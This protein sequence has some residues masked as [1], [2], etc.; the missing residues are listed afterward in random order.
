MRF[1]D[2]TKG[3]NRT[4]TG[5]SPT[6]NYEGAKAFKLDAM[7]ELYSAVCT[8][9]LQPKFYVGEVSKQLQQLRKLI[10]SVSPEMVAKL[11]VYAREK[12]HL[13]SVPLVLAVELAKIHKDDALVGK[14]TERVIQRA[15]ELYEILSYYKQANPGTKEL[16]GG[17]VKSLFKI[18]K[19]LKRGI[20]KAF[21][22]FDEYQFGKYNRDTDIKLRDAMF[23][24]HPKPPSGKIE[25]YKK[26]ADDTLSTPFTWETVLTDRMAEA[27]KGIKATKL[28]E[29]AANA[30]LARTKKLAWEE[31]I[32]SKKVGYMA[33]LRN[34][35]NIMEAVVSEEHSHMVLD[36][37][38]NKEAVE[39]SRQLPFRFYSAYKEI[40]GLKSWNVNQVTEAL[41]TAMKYS[42]AN[43]KGFDA[44]SKVLIACDMSGSMQYPLH[45]KSKVRYYEIGLVLGM[46]LQF[47]CAK[48]M[49]GLFGK[50]W[51][52]ETFWKDNILKNSHAFAG[53][54]GCVGHATNGWKILDWAIKEKV[55]FDKVAFFTDCQ[56]WDSTTEVIYGG[57]SKRAVDYWRKYKELFPDAKAY[58]FDLKGYGTT[59]LFVNEMDVHLIG[60]WSD[61]IFEVLDAVEQGSTAI[62]EI[63]KVE[64]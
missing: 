25:L 58:Y 11:A 29:P 60:G 12:M 32:A 35:R 37:L 61:R 17:R 3:K 50:E 62:A 8:A 36:Y 19:G 59:P 26:I 56:W 1:T 43:I 2:K 34:L 9:S 46:L 22:K 64:L 10:R 31:L 57:A 5:L 7:T 14:L 13:R 55:G 51:R 21:S 54:M 30:I 23:I 15:D 4:T 28:S 38:S 47:K 53:M 42:V 49:T 24:T 39:R 48:A 45:P 52:M 33:L 18:S 20:A 16:S 6:T 41:E 44:D 63:K 40:V 27:R